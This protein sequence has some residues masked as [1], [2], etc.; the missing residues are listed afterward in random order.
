MIKDN[1]RRVGA[2][3]GETPENRSRLS[4]RVNSIEPSGIRRFFDLANELK[5]EVLSLSI[6][7][8]DFVTPWRVR[9]SGIYSLE[10]GYTHYT[11]N[12]GLAALR[13][14]IAVY[15]K[16]KFNLRYDPIHE[17]VITVGGSEALDNAIRALVDPGD[18]VIIPEPCFVSYKASVGLAN[19]VPVPLPLKKEN[20]FKL[21]PEE[22]EAAITPKT[23]LLVL[24]FP[25][26]P[27]GAIMDQW[28]LEALVPVLR[29]HPKISIVSDELYAQLT[30]GETAHFSIANIPE[31]RER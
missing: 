26:N 29:K 21:T 10:Q 13:K 24:G 18:E 19:A 11:A 30:Y 2:Q 17:I 14:E 28:D 25:N 12:Q 31:M 5:G 9:E 8:P 7:E 23:R 20:Q 1:I 3:N 6:G 27:T 4:D 16:E 22:L 15:S